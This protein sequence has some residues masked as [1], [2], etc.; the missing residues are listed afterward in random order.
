MLIV[1]KIH[2]SLFWWNKTIKK[3]YWRIY[4]KF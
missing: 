2:F 4:S 3:N 1:I